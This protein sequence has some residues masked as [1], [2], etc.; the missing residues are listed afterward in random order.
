MA[1]LTTL[2]RALDPGDFRQTLEK[3]ALYKHGDATPLTPA[4]VAA[5]APA[6]IEA[7]V[8]ELIAATADHARARW[9][10]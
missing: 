6:T 3:I 9:A 2:S 10:C 8:D 7:E 1:D 5:M 4:E